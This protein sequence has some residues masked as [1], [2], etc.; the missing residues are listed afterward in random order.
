MNTYVNKRRSQKELKKTREKVAKYIQTY[1]MKESIFPNIQNMAT[2]ANRF[3][4]SVSRQTIHNWAIGKTLP[5]LTLLDN[6]ILILGLKRPTFDPASRPVEDKDVQELEALLA[7]F[8]RLREL[9]YG[10]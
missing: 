10:N 6:Y 2:T 1:M 3:G 4:L 8:Q 9:T 5:M 7:F